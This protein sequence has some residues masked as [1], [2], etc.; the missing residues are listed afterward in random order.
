[1]SWDVL[2]CVCVATCTHK[3]HHFRCFSQCRL[4][5]NHLSLGTGL[6]EQMMRDS[7]SCTSLHQGKVP[8]ALGLFLSCVAGDE[9]DCFTAFNENV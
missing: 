3:Y 6:P 5:L 7:K 4:D 8:L 2:L 1:M 9:S